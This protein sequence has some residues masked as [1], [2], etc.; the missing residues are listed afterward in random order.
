VAERSS[1]RAL[2]ELATPSRWKM[3]TWGIVRLKVEN[4]I[5]RKDTGFS[6][7]TLSVEA[8]TR[9][10]GRPLAE[11]VIGIVLR[12]VGA[13][14]GKRLMKLQVTAINEIVNGKQLM[15]R[16]EM[17]RACDCNTSS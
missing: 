16:W 2:S 3:D 17:S 5:R 4:M 7:H 15:G 13:G 6:D 14:T 1:S 11:M 8:R 9:G 10:G 12:R